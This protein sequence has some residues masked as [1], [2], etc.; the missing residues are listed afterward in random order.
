M[1]LDEKPELLEAYGSLLNQ[2]ISFG[3]CYPLM[4]WHATLLRRE[5]EHGGKA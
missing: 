1:V 5:V 4:F 2:L 3:F